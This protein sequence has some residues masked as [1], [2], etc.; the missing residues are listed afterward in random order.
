MQNI[1]SILTTSLILVASGL[2]ACGEKKEPPL[3][4]FDPQDKVRQRGQG[5]AV[6]GTIAVDSLNNFFHMEHM[7][8]GYHN[9]D[10]STQPAS[11]TAVKPSCSGSQAA[12]ESAVHVII[13][14]EGGRAKKLA[15][16][17]QPS[18]ITF[19]SKTVEE[20]AKDRAEKYLETQTFKGVTQKYSNWPRA[21]G[22]KDIVITESAKPVYVVLTGRYPTLYNFTVAPYAKVSGVL[23]YTDEPHA[24]VADLI[25][26]CQYIFSRQRVGKQNTAGFVQKTSLMK[27]GVAIKRLCA[28][29][30]ILKTLLATIY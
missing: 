13:A 15:D 26:L 19:S 21:M 27:H 8:S 23:V 10:T 1:K 25:H 9:I 17:Q 11:L 4:T 12:A 28:S 22:Q 29:Y 14:R 3:P 18:L 7:V 6:A 30:Q 5:Y 24:A 2:S 20:I 16:I